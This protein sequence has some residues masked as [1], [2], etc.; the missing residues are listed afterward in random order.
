[1]HLKLPIIQ[2]FNHPIFQSILQGKSISVLQKQILI[3]LFWMISVVALAQTGGSYSFD[4]LNTP[5]TARITALSG[6]NVSL[7]D[8]DLNLFFSNPAL[9]GDTLAG[10]VSASYQFY[11]ADIGQATFAYAHRFNKIGVLNLG[12]QHL[13]Y[14]TVTSTDASGQPIG[15]YKSHETAL[16]IGK[17]HQIRHYR[18]GANLKMAFS[19]L[20]GYRASALLIDLGGTFIH[21]TQNLRVGLVIKN[22]GVMLSRYTE[23]SSSLPFDV[24]LGTTFK[25][26]HMPFRFSITA[27]HLTRDVTYYDAANGQD[28]PGALDKVFRRFTF[29]TELLLHKNVNILLGYNYRL[30]QELKLENGGGA[31]GLSYGFSARI[32]SFE[33]IFGRNIYIAGQAGYVFTL[34]SDLNSF[35]KRNVK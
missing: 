22:V 7:A 4:F 32:K 24:Q 31:A 33:F 18:L 21:P 20:A 5:A 15:E 10:V 34:T 29:G 9:A 2:S 11:V 35:L 23:S 13:K 14:G 19:N 17:T 16:V 8:R 1:M 12:I 25:P 26:E 30:H 28:E 6:V 27:Y 3:G